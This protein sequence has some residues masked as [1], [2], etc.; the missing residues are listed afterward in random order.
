MYVIPLI[1]AVQELSAKI[2]T[3]EAEIT[4]LKGE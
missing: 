1:K 2:T 4:K 3:L